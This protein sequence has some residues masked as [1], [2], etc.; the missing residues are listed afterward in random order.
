M[1]QTTID[2]QQSDYNVVSSS[3]DL[4]WYNNRRRLERM[5]FSRFTERQLQ[6]NKLSRID[7]ILPYFTAGLKA[8]SL[9]QRGERNARDIFIQEHDLFFPDLPEAFDGYRILHLTDLHLDSLPGL[10]E[11]I[12]DYLDILQFDIS[13]FTGDYRWHGHGEYPDQVVSALHRIFDAAQAS[14]GVFA[15]L[16]N[17]DTHHIVDHL[18]EMPVRLLANEHIAIQRDGQQ[19]LFTGTDDPHTYHTSEATQVLANSGEGFKVALIHSPELYPEAAEAGYRLYLCGHTHG[20]QVCL[21][22]GWPVIRNLH[23]GKRKVKGFWKHQNM[24][25]YTSNGC[26]VSGAPV[27]FFSRGEVT[28]FT[29]RKKAG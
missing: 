19:I 12:C 29:L 23:R 1:L 21:P 2:Q 17:H 28:L 13:V 24:L 20:G 18:A 3:V 14:D 26:G 6:T 22:T 16:G 4:N 5:R 25:G 11:T 8:I 9:Y 15:T 27:R 10:E 7:Y